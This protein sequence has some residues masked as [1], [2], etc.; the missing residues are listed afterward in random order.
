[1][2]S[3]AFWTAVILFGSL[4][5]YMIVFRWP[6]FLCM[7]GACAT[8]GIIFS[9]QLP[10]STIVSSLIGNLNNSAYV[11]IVFYFLLGELLNN[12]S[13]GDRLFNFLDSIVGHIPGGMSHINVLDSVIFAGVSGS[14]TADTASI[15][16]IMIN[17]MKKEGYPAG[18]AAAITEASAL[19]GPIIPPSNGFVM[20]AIILGCSTRGLFIGGI[21]PGLLM[22]ILMLAVSIYWSYKAHFPCHEWRGW[23]HVAVTFLHGLGAVV[24]PGV[25]IICLLLGIGTVTE[26]GAASCFLAIV[27]SICYR[28][29]SMKALMI[30]VRNAAVTGG[31]IMAILACAG[32]FTW[33]IAYS[34]LTAALS[35]W[36]IALGLSDRAL[37]VLCMGIFFILGFILDPSVLINVITPL[38][39]PALLSAEVDLIWFAVLGLIV[40]NLGNITPPVGQLIY[41]T[42]SLAKCP[43]TETIKYSIPYFVANLVLIILCLIFPGIVTF[44]PNLVMGA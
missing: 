25:T 6:V 41:L 43:S 36:I 28:D 19:I 10:S 7:A 21:I 42:S 11:A 23:K 3:F 9:G 4:F 30:S 18:Y 8:W 26:I 24:L 2:A 39:L 44:L 12:T 13:L 37:M 14:S 5:L 27:I 31:K 35:N 15:G 32:I 40:I 16:S 20:L 33:I 17:M 29:F 34:G 22:G 38:M 1:M